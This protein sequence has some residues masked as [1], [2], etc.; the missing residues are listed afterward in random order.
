MTNFIKIFFAL[1]IS[2]SAEAGAPSDNSTLQN[3]FSDE[4]LNTTI[5]Y[6]EKKF[7]L[8]PKRIK[9]IIMHD[10]SGAEIK[11]LYAEYEVDSCP[12]YVISIYDTQMIMS[13]KSIFTYGCEVSYKGLIDFD[14]RER[15]PLKAIFDESKIQNNYPHFTAMIQPGNVE[16]AWWGKV[17]LKGARYNNNVDVALNVNDSEGLNEWRKLA[18]K[19]GYDDFS[20]NEC[21]SDLDGAAYDLWG[22]ASIVGIGISSGIYQIEGLPNECEA[23]KD[24]G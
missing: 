6:F 14:S 22:D 23:H 7:D 10:D 24:Q 11:S 12:I 4:N 9:K 19:K 2:T 17:V 1:M 20:Y 3:V 18:I 5:P 21:K 13:I 15:L 8:V 16:S